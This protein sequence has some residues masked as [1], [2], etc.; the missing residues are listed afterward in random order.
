MV[1]NSLFIT[2]SWKK[3]LDLDQGNWRQHNGTDK[4]K[5]EQRYIY[6]E[7]YTSRVKAT[8]KKKLCQGNTQ[9]EVVL[10]QHAE[11]VMLRRYA[12]GSRVKATRRK[13][14]VKAICRQKSC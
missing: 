10:R 12:N 13:S 2:G 7:R 11:K 4:R 14:H 1:A 9:T 5:P 3:N 6:R 8:R